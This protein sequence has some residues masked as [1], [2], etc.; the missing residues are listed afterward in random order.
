MTLQTLNSDWMTVPILPCVSIEDTLS[1]WQGLGYIV[2]YRQT[3]P[4]QYGVVERNGFQLH[5]GR[6]K[7][8]QASNNSYTGCLV[9]VK[10]A[11]EVYMMLCASLKKLFRRVPHTGIPRISRMKLGSTRFTLTDVSGNSVIFV[12]RGAEDQERWEETDEQSKSPLQRAM[13]M[14]QRYR[15][16][17]NDDQAAA[18][19]LDVAMQ[20]ADDADPHLPEALIM[21]I[22]LASHRAEK[23]CEETCRRK[24]ASLG[25]DRQTLSSLEDRHRGLGE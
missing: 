12:S 7:G 10:D 21:R 17:K 14:A 3:S 13:A 22:E 5:F 8:L 9:I 2:T 1:F 6:L 4:Y 24:L 15:D 19:I 20:H 11:K 25:L 16:Y 18:K 23:T